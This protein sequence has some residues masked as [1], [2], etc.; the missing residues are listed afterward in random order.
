MI[1]QTKW[2]VRHVSKSTTTLMKRKAFI[3]RCCYIYMVCCVCVCVCVPF[4]VLLCTVMWYAAMLGHWYDSKK[5]ETPSSAD[6][7]QT[8]SQQR[9][10]YYHCTAFLQCRLPS[11]WMHLFASLWEGVGDDQTRGL[12]CDIR[13][14]VWVLKAQLCCRLCCEYVCFWHRVWRACTS[15]PSLFLLS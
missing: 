11:T 3:G 6:W 14:R 8:W 13:K 5:S 10:P 7:F 2:R 1:P 4:L 12:G 15:L 9:R